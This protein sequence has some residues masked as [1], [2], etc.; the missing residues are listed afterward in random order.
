MATNINGINIPASFPDLLALYLKTEEEVN[1]DLSGEKDPRVRPGQEIRKQGAAQIL[2]GLRKAL[3]DSIEQNSGAIFLSGSE[4]G[5]TAFI[6]EAQSQTDGAL[7]IVDAQEMYKMV[8]D[9]IEK[10]LRHDRRFSMDSINGFVTG[11]MKLLDI[12]NV[13][14]IPSPNVSTR[15]N[16]TLATPEDCAALVRSALSELPGHNGGTVGDGLN[17]IYLQ[18][19]AAEEV[20]KEKVATPFIP[21]ILVNATPEETNGSVFRTLFFG[22]NTTFE[23][24]GQDVLPAAVVQVFKQLRAARKSTVVSWKNSL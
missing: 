12:T 6:A 5:V 4:A 24:K 16:R 8:G 22:R 11:V 23:A 2:P 9:E 21:V 1:I 10:T 18:V 13:D 20:I 14:G 15:L 3:V 7:V 19:R 17:A